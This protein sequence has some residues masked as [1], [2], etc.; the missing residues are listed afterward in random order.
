MLWKKLTES[1]ETSESNPQN[2][3]LTTAKL[4]E[5]LGMDRAEL[6]KRLCEMGLQELKDKHYYLTEK[7]K[8]AGAT[9]RKGQYGLFI[10]WASDFTI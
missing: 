2:T 3:A 9:L 7:G 8:Q 6:N 10:L 5:K 1:E 4:A